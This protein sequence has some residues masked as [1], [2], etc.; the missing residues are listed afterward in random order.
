MRQFAVMMLFVTPLLGGAE[1]RGCAA[2]ATTPAPDMSGTWA[3]TYADDLSVRITIGGAV[4]ERELG[5]QGGI[6]DIDHNGQ[7]FM[8]DL[9]CT[10]D[11]VVCPSEVWPAS[12][13]FRQDDPNFPHRVWM[14]VPKTVCRG[15][16]VAPEMSECGEGT[17]NPGC[18]M[19]CD[20]ETETVIREAFGVIDHPGETFTLAL[21]ATVA[22]NGINCALLGASAAT[23]ELVNEG[24]SS[25]EDW[26]A[27]DVE[28]GEVVTAFAGGCLWAGDPNMD[29]ELE[30]LVL[31]ATVEFRTSYTAQ[32]Q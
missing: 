25:S 1:S 26:V 6:I 11:E 31:A 5:A 20:G 17:N 28:N 9:D 32:K 29:G 2:N 24:A 30:A 21:G 14:Q 13:D 4:Y 22:T 23:G 15:S 16:E 10:R 7:P 8:F 12:V 27:T 19:V 3:V 18:D